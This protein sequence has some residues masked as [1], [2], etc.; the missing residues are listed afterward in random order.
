MLRVLLSGKFLV[1]AWLVIC[2]GVVL[3]AW[4][5]TNK[6]LVNNAGIKSVSMKMRNE[7]FI[8]DVILNS[9]MP[10]QQIYSALQIKNIIIRDKVYTPEC[11]IL[12]PFN[13]RIY[14]K[15]SIS[16]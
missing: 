8:L 13:V 16:V 1:A 14:Y 3:I 2:A 7:S 5:D 11:E 10:C 4:P 6:P 15:E 12:T 9:P